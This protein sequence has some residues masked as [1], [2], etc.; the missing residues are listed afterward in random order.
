MMTLMLVL[1]IPCILGIFFIYYYTKMKL[2]IRETVRLSWHY[3]LCNKVFII[4]LVCCYISFYIAARLVMVTPECYANIYLNYDGASSG[5]N[6]NGTRYNAAEI[7]SD[8]V[9]E[10]AVKN[11]DLDGITKKMLKNCL[12]Q[13][14][15]DSDSAVI[16]AS[17]SSDKYTIQTGYRINFHN[18]D[19][20]SNLNAETII[21]AVANAYCD[22]F[23]DAYLDKHILLNISEEELENLDN[24]DYLD[25]L[26]Y[27][28]VKASELQRYLI[29]YQTQNSS[30]QSPTTGETFYSLYDKIEHFVDIELE[31]FESYVLENG[32]SKNA[33]AYINKLNYDNKMTDVEYQKDW[34]TYKTYLEAVDRYHREMATVVLVP[35]EDDDE[36][37]YMSRTKIGVDYLSNTAEAYLQTAENKMLEINT[38]NH[39]IEQLKGG[40]PTEA[41]FDKV[42]KTYVKMKEE[43]VDFA[44]QCEQLISEYLSEK[45]GSYLV[46]NIS[47][48]SF[49]EIVNMKLMILCT[50]VFVVLVD[51]LAML[52]CF[53]K[54]KSGKMQAKKGKRLHSGRKEKLK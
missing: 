17:D 49:I 32:I 30:Y 39:A 46:V 44:K 29:E 5:L 54:R 6:P 33:E 50:V 12:E 45:E 27:F 26:N 20:T 51:A 37:F 28:E 52:C 43:L 36:E 31:R 19:K 23:S 11:G 25:M 2:G 40:E 8:E 1:L 38:N 16:T 7:L 22:Y 18:P 47:R 10:L 24:M 4:L 34:A 14:P 48:S 53:N 15:A 13:K 9:L 35:T 41:V 3:F 21:N 42:E